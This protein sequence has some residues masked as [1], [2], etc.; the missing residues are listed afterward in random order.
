GGHRHLGEMSGTLEVEVEAEHRSRKP[1]AYF[2][3]EKVGGVDRPE[4]PS[5]AQ[6]R[7]AS[8]RL[9]QREL[10][11]IDLGLPEE[12]A[13]AEEAQARLRARA[14]LH[15]PQHAR[16]EQHAERTIGVRAAAA[17]GGDGEDELAVGEAEQHLEAEALAR[18]E[19]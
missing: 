9:H 18:A 8:D 1:R 12:A 3:A 17:C 16:A 13:G 6:R 15:A 7:V 2:R 19:E 4:R 10:D 14:G 11:A 5:G